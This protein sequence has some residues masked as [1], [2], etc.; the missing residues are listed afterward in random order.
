MSLRQKIAILG[1]GIGGISAAFALTD[2]PGWQDKYEI[3]VYQMG[4][5]L[6]GKCA[7]GRDK[8]YGERIL[9][10]GLHIWLGFYE[11]A[12]R[13]IRKCYEELGWPADKPMATWQ[14]A[15]KKQSLVTLMEEIDGEWIRWPIDFPTN[16]LVP[17][18]GGVLLSPWD[19]VKMLLQFLLKS[20]DSAPA[21][22]TDW[23]QAIASDVSSVFRKVDTVVR[24][25]LTVGTRALDDL[26]ASADDLI[27]DVMGLANRTKLHQADALA[28]ALPEDPTE[29]MA[30]HHQLLLLLLEDFRKDFLARVGD[31][32][33]TNNDLRRLAIWLQLGM[34]II[35]GMIRDGVIFHGFDAIDQYD[36][37]EWLQRHGVTDRKVWWSA[38]VRG[39]YELVFAYEGG[40]TNHPNLAAGAGLRGAL[41]MFFGYKGAIFWKMQ[42]GMAD[43]IFTPM[44]LV[45]KKRGVQFRFFHRVDNLGLSADGQCVDT[46]QVGVQATVKPEILQQQ[47]G[48]QPFRFVKNLPCWPDQPLYEQLVEGATLAKQNICLESAWTPWPDVAKFSLKRGVDF[49]KV[50][51]GVPLG[52][53]PFICKELIAARSDWQQMVT[54]VKTVQTLAMQ[55]WFSRDAAQLGWIAPE[56]ALVSSYVEPFDAWADMSQLLEREDWPTTVTVANIAYLCGPLE[57]AEK[58]PPPF[59][60]PQFP[61]SQLERVRMQ[62]LNFLQTSVRPL[63]PLATSPENPEG[64][65]WQ[66]LVD[67]NGGSGEAR[68]DA[69]YFRANIDPGERYVLSVKGSTQ[70]RIQSDKSGFA[71]LYLAGDW[72]YNGINAGCVEAATIS[73]FQAA[74]AICGYPQIIVGESDL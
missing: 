30:E 1:G 38:V 72:T 42:S 24:D 62:G 12:F 67:P 56:H 31:K 22:A 15:F 32:L 8:N 47:Q 57:D 53:L 26:A 64:L 43:T 33:F 11:N 59:T 14:Q 10:H 4:W 51:L 2:E 25:L 48:Y 28:R 45:L 65:D 66:W 39:I 44:Y 5:R 50:I 74:R 36:L 49:D 41:R 23:G 6:G 9:E 73:G 35:S 21:A 20:H 7:S 13:A 71:N 46:I 63:W 55:L 60:D 19:Y 70:Y 37:T 27:D 17:G 18:D 68:V 3:T 16:D 29:H 40:N 34:A 52:A 69:Q 54:Q 61:A 58:L